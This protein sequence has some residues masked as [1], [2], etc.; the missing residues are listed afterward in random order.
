MLEDRL[1]ATS[2]ALEDVN[3][4]AAGEGYYQLGEV[5]RRAV[6]AT[7]R[8]RPSAGRARSASSLNPVRRC[9]AAGRVTVRPR[10]RDLRVALASED[11]LGR[12]RLL[13]GAV[14]V[15]LVRDALDE[16]EQHC[17]ELES[18]A[19]AFGTPGFRAWAAHARGAIL[20]RRARHAEALEP[21][22]SAL[23][24]Y[25][26]QQSR[27]DTAQ[28]YEWMAIAH[29]AL[30]DD[31]AAAA[32]TATAENIYG[33]LGV[34]PAQ[35]GGPTSPGGLTKRE[36]EILKRIAGG[37]TNRQVA[38]QLFISE[39]TVG[40]HLANIYTKLGVSSRTAAAAWAHQNNALT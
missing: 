32:D 13:R 23:R 34:A 15:A 11:R 5:R 16:A 3:G 36:I 26:T 37:A 40:R 9:C 2:R 17:S 8:L 28:V 20:V 1:L 27:Y 7:A 6:T 30:G 22:Q 18:G 10:G 29:R 25:R 31:A 21:L 35:V 19:E 38:E 4:W 12:M 24:E 33:Q 39:K 14:E